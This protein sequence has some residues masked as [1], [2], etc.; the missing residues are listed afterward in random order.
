MTVPA[1]GKASAV[2][3]ASG[4][5]LALAYEQI[6]SDGLAGVRTATGSSGNY[7]GQT[8]AITPAP[9]AIC[10]TDSF[11]RTTLGADW[12]TSNS[13]GGF[14][15]IINASTSRLQLT[16]NS[17]DQATLA[18]L[19]RYFPAAGNNVVVSFKQYAYPNGGGT[20]LTAS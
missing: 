18:T 19:Q 8:I 6:A 12:A 1:N 14:S 4:V 20:G 7:V 2:S 17:N 15:P 10:F 11:N 9:A 3:G 13:K 16:E 5:Q